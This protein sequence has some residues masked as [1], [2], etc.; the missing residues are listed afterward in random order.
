[1]ASQENLHVLHTRL[2][3]ARDARPV[4]K[5]CGFLRWRSL[6][7]TSVVV[8]SGEPAAAKAK[9]LTIIVFDNSTIRSDFAHISTVDIKLSRTRRSRS[10][11]AS[12]SAASAAAAPTPK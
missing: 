7:C 6:S 10:S 12:S 8:L 9:V 4:K 3:D 2:A 1:M 11:S 5:A